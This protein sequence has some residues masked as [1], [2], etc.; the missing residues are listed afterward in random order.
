[1]FIG[2]Q[3]FSRWCFIAGNKSDKVVLAWHYRFLVDTILSDYPFKS[4][5]MEGAII[6]QCIY[7]VPWQISIIFLGLEVKGLIAATFV[8]EKLL[9]VH[10]IAICGEEASD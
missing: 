5:A 6:W 1:M 8:Q 2:M 9:S 10:G 4:G 7:Y 3:K